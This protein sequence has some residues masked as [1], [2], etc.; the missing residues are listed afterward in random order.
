[1]PKYINADNLIGGARDFLAGAFYV[2][3][4]GRS[5]KTK[6]LIEHLIHHVVRT[7]PAEDVVAVVRCE[8]CAKREK[9]DEF[10]WCKPCGYRCHDETWYCPAG[11]RRAEDG[12]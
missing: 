3:T 7:A 9:K 6:A 2:G 10:F 12:K 11:V 1:M 5:G 8:V 4:P